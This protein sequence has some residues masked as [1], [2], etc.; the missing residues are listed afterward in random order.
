MRSPFSR[1]PDEVE[2]V[3]PVEL[4]RARALLSRPP[5]A[6][7][8]GRHVSAAA[9]TAAGAAASGAAEAGQELQAG[10]EV[11]ELE[12]EIEVEVEVPAVAPLPEPAVQGAATL[13]RRTTRAAAAV[14][15]AATLGAGLA[16]PAALEPAQRLLASVTERFGRPDVPEASP[17]EPAQLEAAAPA[18]SADSRLRGSGRPAGPSP[19]AA[20]ASPGGKSSTTTT[21]EVEQ[22][23]VPSTTVPLATAPVDGAEPLA[24]PEDC[25]AGDGSGSS[26]GSG[27]GSGG[28]STDGGSGGEQGSTEPTTTTT[29]PPSPPTSEPPSTT[30]T[31]TPPTTTTTAPA[32]PNSGDP[33]AGCEPAEQPVEDAAGEQVSTNGTSP[34]LPGALPGQG[35]ATVAGGGSS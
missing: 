29:A 19:V 27:D 31:T 9:A 3:P 25:P 28:G 24:G 23:Q 20:P 15:V 4:L 6:E 33:A 5:G 10:F 2:I 14:V 21:T 34:S 7:V 11:A 17:A 30:T 12:V 35:H 18:P 22:A 13:M 32:D 16:A 8:S 26:D 1:P